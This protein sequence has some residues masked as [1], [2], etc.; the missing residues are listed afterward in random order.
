MA[1]RVSINDDVRNA[2]L[3]VLWHHQ[4]G[5]SRVGQPIRLMLGI[6][7]HEHLTSE[8]LEKAKAWQQLLSLRR[9]E[10][11]AWLGFSA[12]DPSERVVFMPGEPRS[13]RC[14]PFTPLYAAPVALEA[15]AL[16]REIDESGV[17]FKHAMDLDAK[18]ANFLNAAAPEAE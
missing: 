5:S 10:P 6:G 4:G 17:L 12:A 18:V 15:L 14:G 11:C 2:L 9:Q 3:F 16:L 7:E 8:Q 1:E 13:D